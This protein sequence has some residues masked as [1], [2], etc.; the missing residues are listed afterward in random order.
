[1]A[2]IVKPVPLETPETRENPGTKRVAAA[3]IILYLFYHR[4][5]S[6]FETVA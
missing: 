5:C 6:I 2:L 3:E 4:Y 1:L